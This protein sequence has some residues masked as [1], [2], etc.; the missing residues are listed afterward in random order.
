MKKRTSTSGLLFVTAQLI[1]CFN[2]SLAQN[3]IPLSERLKLEA[4]ADEQKGKQFER[5]NDYNQASA[6]F[7]KA[8]NFYWVNGSPEKAIGLYGKAYEMSEKLGS[9]NAQYV[10]STNLG[11]IY[12]DISAH[13]KASH[14]FEVATSIAK[15]LGRRND[16]ASSMLNQANA[17]FE[18]DRLQQTLDAINAANAIA[19]EV[20]DLKLLRNTYSLYT[21]VY[22]KMGKRDESA[23]YFNL[24]AVISKKIQEE[25]V[26]K[27]ENEAK[28][29][30]TQAESKVQTVVAEKRAT[31]KVLAEKDIELFL[32]QRDLERTQLIAREKEN[33]IKL[34][35]L[36]RERQNAIISKQNLLRNIY[37]IIILTV[38]VISGLIYNLYRHKKRANH[39]LQLK[40]N[41]ISR[42]NVE[43]K[44]QAQLLEE[45]NQIK[46][47]LFSIIS[48]DLRS[49]IGSLITLLSLTEQGYLEED[50][51]KKVIPELNKNVGYTSSL[52]EN[53]L[54]WSQS[55]LKGI[56]IKP[57]SFNVSD[58]VTGKFELLFEQA[59]AKGVTLEIDSDKKHVVLADKDMVELILRNL[60]SNSIKF[61]NPSDKIRV[62]S[63]AKD[64]LIEICVTDTGVGMSIDVIKNLFGTQMHSSPGTQNEKGTGLGLILCKDFVELNGGSIWVESIKGKGSKFYFTIPAGEISISPS[65]SERKEIAST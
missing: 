38:V 2:S 15:K 12:T 23:K 63:K 27:R 30:V 55:Q 31:E 61:C 17:L 52:L 56:T 24:F 8:G 34:L 49:P 22:D 32:K 40:N 57:V 4:E 43:I 39:L 13:E 37:I 6:H 62:T 51:F 14:Q 41:E 18:L 42:Q 3:A 64:G 26:V 19:Q 60:V 35:N 59:K 29:M 44:A 46:D 21:K 25:E 65:I 50:G 36:E 54:K 16:V 5:A 7:S 33:E 48:H 28:L 11:M 58:I 53:L 9:L 47:K 10:L 45:L 1:L 20:N